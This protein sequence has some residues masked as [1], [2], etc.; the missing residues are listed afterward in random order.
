MF[1]RIRSKPQLYAVIFINLYLKDEVADK[2]S[3]HPMTH[4]E[5]SLARQKTSKHDTI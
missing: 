4:I 5:H 2:V 1:S 3:K